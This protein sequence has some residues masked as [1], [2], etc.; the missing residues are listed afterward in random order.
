ML[1]SAA[2]QWGGA[3]GPGHSAWGPGESLSMAA[4]SC[5]LLVTDDARG[6]H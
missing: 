6:T 4:N 3:G 5:V 2:E 1:D